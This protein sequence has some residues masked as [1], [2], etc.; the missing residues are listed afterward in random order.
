MTTWLLP[1]LTALLGYGVHL[2]QAALARRHKRK[3]ADEERIAALLIKLVEIGDL[4]GDDSDRGGSDLAAKLWA[5]DVGLLRNKKLRRRLSEDLYMIQ[6]LRLMTGG[7][8][9][10]GE[11]RTT[12]ASDAIRCC[13]AVLRGDR[14][15]PLDGMAERQLYDAWAATTP[16]PDEHAVNTYLNA[17]DPE[18]VRREEGFLRWQAQLVPWW[19]R[20]P[21]MW[22][23]LRRS[24]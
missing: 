2:A 13:Q 11:I 6:S 19:R 21:P 15:P 16:G 18:S 14:L 8:H 23:R 24:E 12:W 20:S 10:P 5:T 7:D 9:K 4:A 22:R 1:I 17:I 3:D